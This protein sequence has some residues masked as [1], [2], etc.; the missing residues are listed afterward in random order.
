[1]NAPLSCTIALD[2][3][4]LNYYKATAN[5]LLYKAEGISLETGIVVA[6]FVYSLLIKNAAVSSTI[7]T[8]NSLQQNSSSN[9]FFYSKI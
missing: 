2:T 4:I 5:N 1:V 6:F 3:D 8:T 7:L 9:I